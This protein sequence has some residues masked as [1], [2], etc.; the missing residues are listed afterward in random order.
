MKVTRYKPQAFVT[1]FTES[2][3][4]VARATGNPDS[5]IDNDII[6]IQTNRD[7]GADAP[8]FSIELTRRKSW[9]KWIGSNDKVSIVMHRPPEKQATVF[10]GLVD[11]CRKRVSIQ[12]ESVQR[13]ISVTG[14]GAAKAFVQFDIGVVPEAEYASTTVGWLVSNGITL[15][16]ASAKSIIQTIWDNIAKKHVNYKWENGQSLFSSIQ[17]SLKDKPSM[18]LLD[19]SDRKSVV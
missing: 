19:D 12:G 15:S 18:I 5:P 6:R 14:R 13:S 3:E 10:V 4:L 7:M 9:H 11:D 1:F 16:G 8:T 17:I 2:G